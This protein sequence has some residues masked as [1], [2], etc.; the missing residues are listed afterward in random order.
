MLE[1]II[2]DMR[3][4]LAGKLLTLGLRAE[5]ISPVLN[6]IQDVIVANMRVHAASGKGY[7]FVTALKDKHPIG[8]H[9]LVQSMVMDLSF[10]L[11][12]YYGIGEPTA[13]SIAR[14]VVPFVMNRIGH[15]L[16]GPADEQALLRSMQRY[17]AFDQIRSFGRQFKRIMA[18]F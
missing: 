3:R 11:Y 8:N 10:K 2:R 16:A 15:S 13:G 18:F 7:E 14:F 1:G 12:A 6:V 9:L 4:D 17:T 5:E